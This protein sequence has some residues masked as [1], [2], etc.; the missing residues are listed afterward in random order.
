[1]NA[2]NFISLARLLSVPVIVWLILTQYWMAAFWAFVAAGLSDALDGAIAKRTGQITLAG[3]Y[4]DPIADK[5]LLVAIYVT[6]G[7]AGYLP[8]W[9]VILVVSRDLLIVGGALLAQTLAL[10]LKIR[11]LIVSKVNTGTQIVLA[12]IVL[13]ELASPAL[14]GVS[15]GFFTPGLVFVVGATTVAS[16]LTYLV[17]WGRRIA[18]AKE[19]G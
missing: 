10:G 14:H 2:P 19:A 15:A 12:G 4:L 18:T 9:L 1:M 13:G 17:L 3:R 7:Q 11:P 8:V 6:L 16:G 5:T